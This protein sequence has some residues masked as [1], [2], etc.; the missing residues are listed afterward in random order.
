MKQIKSLCILLLA[1][2]GIVSCNKPDDTQVTLYSDA[3]IIAFSLTDVDNTFQIDQSVSQYTVSINE[4]KDTIVNA[5]HIFNTD[6]LDAGTDL[7]RQLLTISTR[8]NGVATVRDTTE[9]SLWLYIYSTDSIDVSTPRLVRVWS[10]DG[11]GYADYVLEVRV[12][13]EK[14]DTLVWQQ[15]DNAGVDDAITLPDGIGQLLGKSSKE[16]YALSTTGQLMVKREGATTFEPDIADEADAAKLPTNVVA[17]TSFPVETGVDE[18]DYLLLAGQWKEETA[19]DDGTT[20]TVWH[21][22]VWRKIVDYSKGAATAQWVYMERAKELYDLPLMSSLALIYYDGSVLA[23]GRPTESDSYTILQSRDNGIT[24]KSSSL[25]KL[26]EGFNHSA[27]QVTAKVDDDN[28]IWLR[29]EGTGQVWR[30]RL[31]RLAWK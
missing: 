10:S 9:T 30:G 1:I 17:F 15:I 3:E 27:T 19:L 14:G 7:T 2:A 12:H 13:Q 8:N 6:S 29:C 5:R 18:V 25:F 26:P 23:I 4:N 21:S 28:N 24:W 16:E 11:T 22:A 20:E 31:N